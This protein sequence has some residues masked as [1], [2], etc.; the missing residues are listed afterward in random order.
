MAGD[1]QVRERSLCQCEGRDQLGLPLATKACNMSSV[2]KQEGYPPPW[3][4]AAARLVPVGDVALVLCC[5][6]EKG[7]LTLPVPECSG[8]LGPHGA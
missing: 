6:V 4:L 3:D 7:Q 8:H 1:Q 5:P 2:D